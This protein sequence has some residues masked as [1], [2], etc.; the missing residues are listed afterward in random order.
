[1]IAG[2][3][4]IVSRGLGHLLFQFRDL[5]NWAGY[6]TAL[7]GEVQEW[8]DALWGVVLSRALEDATGDALDQWGALLNEARNGLTDEDYRAILDT[9]ILINHGD[10][11]IPTVLDVLGRL[12]GSNN[13]LLLST[14]PAGLGLSYVVPSP[15]SVLRRARIVRL[16]RAAVADGVRIDHIAEVPANWFGFEEDPGAL[17]FGLGGWATDITEH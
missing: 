14:P 10:H 4:N 13:V 5:P 17:G 8:A 16:V 12:T 9:K 11:T 1:M 6:M 3:A 2:I 15:L 7:L